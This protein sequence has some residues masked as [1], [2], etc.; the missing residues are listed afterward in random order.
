MSLIDIMK[1]EHGWPT[2][3]EDTLEAFV[4]GPG[5]R[6]LFVTGDPARNLETNDVAVIL[7]ELSRAFDH[8]F[9][10]AVVAR[11]IER[12]VRERFDTFAMPSLIFLRDGKH[13]GSIAKVR[14]WDDYLERIALILGEA[15]ATAGVH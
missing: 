15:P 13:L 12:A 4:S 3:D 2:L 9:R 8:R 1:A 5:E 6:V 11:E 10:A 14:D 7:P